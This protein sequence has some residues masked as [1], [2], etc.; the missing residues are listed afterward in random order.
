[1]QNYITCQYSFMPG[2]NSKTP[3]TCFT[4]DSKGGKLK[5]HF[6]NLFKITDSINIYLQIN[7]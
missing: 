6:L 7:L 2:I 4:N 3:K 5:F 1:M